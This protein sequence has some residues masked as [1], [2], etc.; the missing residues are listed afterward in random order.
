M[1]AKST[2][3]RVVADICSSTIQTCQGIFNLWIVVGHFPTSDQSF[4]TSCT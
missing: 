2:L 4:L 3:N 1:L